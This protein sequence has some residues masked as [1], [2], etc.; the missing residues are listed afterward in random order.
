[1][2][3]TA[4]LSAGADKADAYLEIVEPPED[5]TVIPLRFNPTDYQV[6]KSNNF[7]EIAIPGLESPPI[8][9]IRGGAEVLS[10]EFLL[11]TSDS[12]KDVRTEY[13]DEIRNLMKPNASLHA[14]P[15][16]RFVWEKQSFTG[17]IQSLDITYTLFDEKGVPLRARMAVSIKE[18]RPAAVQVKD[19]PRS[20]PDVDKTWTVRRGD[21]L[22]SIAGAVYRDPGR[23]RTIAEANDVLD[24]RRL[25][26][27]TVLR[28]PRLR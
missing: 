27:G 2:S 3:L 18:Y 26:P 15:V 8:Q 23:W 20:S 13:V 11:D 4:L 28:I 1:M 12:L 14:P 6:K 24:P 21:S 16:V 25:T 9:F 19:P 10:T 7:A 22:Q 17:V 5:A